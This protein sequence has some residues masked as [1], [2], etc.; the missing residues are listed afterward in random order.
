[1]M[2]LGEASDS[3]TASADGEGTATVEETRSR[4]EQI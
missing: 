3:S 4:Q 1:M 2:F